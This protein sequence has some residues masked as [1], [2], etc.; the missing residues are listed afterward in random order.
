[1]S[2]SIK[3]CKYNVDKILNF[4]E[5]NIVCPICFKKNVLNNNSINT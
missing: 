1:M 5:N 4:L 2:K 3:D